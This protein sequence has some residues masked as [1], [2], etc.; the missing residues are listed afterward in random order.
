MAKK[1]IKTKKQPAAKPIKSSAQKSKSDPKAVAVPIIGIGAGLTYGP[2][3][4]THHAIEDI[5]VMS[6]LPNMT[7]ICPGDPLEAEK[8]VAAA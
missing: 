8:A 1:P 3:G 6:A 4:M 2:A 5:A 7:V